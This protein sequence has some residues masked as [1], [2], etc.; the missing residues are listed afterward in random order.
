MGNK[1]F[2]T[3]WLMKMVVVLRYVGVRVWLFLCKIFGVFFDGCVRAIV[4]SE[5]RVI[6]CDVCNFRQ[7]CPNQYASVVIVVSCSW[8]VTES[9]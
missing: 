1:G 7:A 5:L 3:F 8:Y 9:T 6:L 2:V 4:S